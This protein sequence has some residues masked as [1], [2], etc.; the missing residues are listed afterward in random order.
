[1]PFRAIHFTDD[2]CPAWVSCTLGQGLGK[3]T[4]AGRQNGFPWVRMGVYQ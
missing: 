1:V 4:G 2:P 3:M